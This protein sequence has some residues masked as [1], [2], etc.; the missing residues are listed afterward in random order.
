MLRAILTATG[1]SRVVSFIGSYHGGTVGAMSIS[2]H[3]SQVSAPKLPNVIFLPYPDPYRPFLGDPSGQSVLELLDFHLAKVRQ[4]Y[5]KAR[6]NART[7]RQK[8]AGPIAQGGQL[9]GWP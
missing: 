1:R 3:S 9:F 5:K 2:G 6:P 8:A 7:L 4:F